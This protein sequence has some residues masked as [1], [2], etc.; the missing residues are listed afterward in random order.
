[1]KIKQGEYKQ[2][3]FQRVNRADGEVIQEPAEDVRF[4]ARQLPYTDIAI[5]KKLGNGISFDAE[6]YYYTIT[7]Q[8]A[9]TKGLKPAEYGFDIWVTKNHADLC[10]MSGTLE[11]V[12]SYEIK[13]RK[14]DGKC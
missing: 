14:P 11:V 6:T 9:D 2:F 12:N 4:V 1:M 8:E 7:L 10:I 13:E 3:T 5:E